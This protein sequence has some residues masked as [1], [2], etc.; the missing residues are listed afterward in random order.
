VANSATDP[1]PSAHTPGHVDCPVCEAEQRAAE[2]GDSLAV[3]TLGQAAAKWIE[4]KRMFLQPRTLRDYQQYFRA[5]AEFFGPMKLSAIRIG[6]VRSYQKWRTTHGPSRPD[7][8][9]R[10][11]GAGPTRI[12]NEVRVL[13]QLLNEAHLWQKLRPYHKPLPEPLEG[14]GI[15]LSED[16]AKHLFKVAAGNKRWQVALWIAILQVQ[17]TMGP[18]E[19]THLQIGDIDL[20]GGKLLIRRA[21]KNRFRARPCY[22]IPTTAFI[23]RKLLERARKLG[24]TEPEH[25]L[26]PRRRHGDGGTAYDPN[27]PQVS[28]RSAWN[29]IRKAAGMP[30][31]RPYDMRHTS[32]TWLAADPTVS[33]QTVGEMAGWSRESKMIKRYSH[34]PRDAKVAAMQSA[35]GQLDLFGEKSPSSPN[36][37]EELEMI[38]KKVQ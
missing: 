30:T 28:W 33:P 36:L 16:R 34:Q 3:L 15:A 21:L 22:L 7:H 17:S 25:Y 11:S 23:V 26:L 27:R 19:V 10:R 32:I 13:G 20:P 2:A 5:L 24:A 35:F 9:G 38:S 18:G 12:N 31:L 37:L 4:D 29:S 1:P 14:P 6:N 8:A